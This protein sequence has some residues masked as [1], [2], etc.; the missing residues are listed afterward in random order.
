M[1]GTPPP[2][3]RLSAGALLALLLALCACAPAPTFED[4]SPID[5]SQDPEQKAI[6]D[7]E[8]FVLSRAGYRIVLTPLASY[9]LRGV[10]L[11]EH[12]YHFDVSS[13][14]APCDV[15]VAWGKLVQGD[16]YKHLSWSQDGRWYNWRYGADFAADDAFVSR[17]SSNNHVIPAS[18]FLEKAV[19][20]IRSGDVVEMGGKLVRVEGRKGDSTFHWTSSTSRTDREGGSCEL[21]YLERLKVGAKVYR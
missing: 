3:A 21:I 14:L 17:W 2:A 18:E 4:P 10:V 6:D 11:G 19:K 20:S 8:P 7:P 15:A 16:L 5:I 13:D 9:V 12:D 1:N